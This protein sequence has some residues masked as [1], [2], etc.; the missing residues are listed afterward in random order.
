MQKGFKQQTSPLLDCLLRHLNT[1]LKSYCFLNFAKYFANT[2]L[3]Y[4]HILFLHIHTFIYTDVCMC[5]CV[6][7]CCAHVFSHS[8]WFNFNSM[9]CGPSSASIHGILQARILQWV[10]ISFSR[11][12]SRPRDR[13]WVSHIGGRRLY[14]LW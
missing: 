2:S 1:S 10:A 13:T 3:N 7:T 5:M 11:G 6:C 14:L 12:S 9:D 4:Q 8:V